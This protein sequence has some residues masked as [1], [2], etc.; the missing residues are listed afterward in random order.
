MC[1]VWISE[2]TAIIS[3]YSVKR[4]VFITETDFVYWAVRGECLYTIQ[5]NFRV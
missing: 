5:L 2:K 3:L 1:S 4:L